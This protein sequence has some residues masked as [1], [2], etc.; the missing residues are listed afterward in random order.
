MGIPIKE[1]QD[2]FT[3]LSQ[4]SKEDIA[5]RYKIILNKLK[6]SDYTLIDA[7]ARAL[8]Q[9]V[10][11]IKLEPGQLLNLLTLLP[12]PALRDKDIL[13]KLTPE[14]QEKLPPVKASL[15]ALALLGAAFDPAWEAVN[16]YTSDKGRQLMKTVPQELPGY[17]TEPSVTGLAVLRIVHSLEESFDKEFTEAEWDEIV[18]ILVGMVYEGLT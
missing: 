10:T 18:P 11:Q 12:N 5:W 14:E 7:L 17:N 13:K 4:S 2:A 8:E 3:F 1:L 6:V 16:L 15:A 9:Q